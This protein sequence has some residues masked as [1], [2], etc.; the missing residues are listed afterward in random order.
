QA[1]R[2]SRVAGQAAIGLFQDQVLT[3]TDL[4][5]EGRLIVEAIGLSGLAQP[6]RVRVCAQIVE[7]VP[8]L[9]ED[10]IHQLRRLQLRQNLRALVGAVEDVYAELEVF[11]RRRHWFPPL[12]VIHPADS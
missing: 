6:V 11:R 1:R 8:E 7:L 4:L 9:L 2:P 12:A 3:L 10:G 5:A